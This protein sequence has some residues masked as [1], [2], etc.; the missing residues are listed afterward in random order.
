MKIQK[1]IRITDSPGSHHAKATIEKIFINAEQE[2]VG[3]LIDH[4]RK[5]KRN[6]VEELES[7]EEC[8]KSKMDDIRRAEMTPV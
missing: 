3:V 4:Y 7:I 5:V 1:E 2:V 8:I 6:T